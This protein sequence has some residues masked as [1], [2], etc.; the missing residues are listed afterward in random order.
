M[1]GLLIAFAGCRGL[2]S[3]DNVL[4]ITFTG[5]RTTNVKDGLSTSTPTYSAQTAIAITKISAGTANINVVAS[6]TTTSDQ[7]S[8][9]WF[10]IPTNAMFID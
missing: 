7:Q 4:K 3:A 6:Q 5:A 8:M 2:T 9:G 10:F 1:S